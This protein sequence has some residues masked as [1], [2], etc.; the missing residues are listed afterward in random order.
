MERYT[1]GLAEESERSCCPLCEQLQQGVRGLVL[2]DGD[3]RQPLCRPCGKKVAPTM[4]ALLELAQT[5]ERVGRSCRHLLTPP[6]ESLLDLA[7]AAENY[8]CASL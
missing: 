5:A 6:M 2:Y 1:I 8:C 4:V 7:R 3:Q